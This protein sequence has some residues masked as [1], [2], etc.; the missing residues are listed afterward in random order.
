MFA[1][2][3]HTKDLVRMTGLLRGNMLSRVGQW[4][5]WKESA[6]LDPVL[7]LNTHVIAQ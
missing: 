3:G 2:Q 5:G 6:W 7:L 4:H 1:S